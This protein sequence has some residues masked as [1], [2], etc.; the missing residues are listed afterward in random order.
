VDDAYVEGNETFSIALSN[1]SG[2]LFGS[3]STAT[4][5][6]IDND[7]V[8]GS[9]PINQTPNFVSQQYVDFLG[10]LPDANGF[11]F[12]QNEITSCGAN[13]PC[14]DVKRVNVSGAFFLSIEFQESGYF[15]Y[16][17][18][19]AA[20]GNLSGVPVPIR[21]SEFLSD[22]QQI[23]NEVVVNAPGWE[24]QLELNKTSYVANFTM[25]SKFLNVYPFTMSPAVF[26]DTLNQNADGALSA[27]ERDALVN[28]LTAGAK[29]R[30]EVLR[31]V[32]DDQTLKDAELNRAFVLMQYFGYL[33]RNPND[34]PEATRDFS[35][36][37]FWLTKLNQ[38]HGDFI[39]AEMVK[40]FLDSTEYRQRFGLP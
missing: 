28:D 29:T 15:A 36:F 24:Q 2:V 34:A 26:V 3:P 20:Y 23:D 4:I 27:S 39:Q 12:W 8:A 35:G 6:I 1:P 7:T 38:F 31:A 11:A 32:A 9:N 17:V 5:T 18:H 14:A 21:L 19:K 16:R 22:A 10:R 40:A 13:G 30:A 33:R 37:N 25:T